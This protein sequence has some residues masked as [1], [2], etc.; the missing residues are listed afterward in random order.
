MFSKIFTLD[1]KD[2]VNGL[3]VAVLGATLGTLQQALQTEGFSLWLYDWGSVG[4]LALNAAVAYLVK[5]FLSD[6][7]GRTFGR[8]G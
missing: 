8:I 2:L 1:K 5:S 6:K 3:V 4:R 7:E